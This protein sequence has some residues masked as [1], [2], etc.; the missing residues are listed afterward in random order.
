MASEPPAVVERR[1]L[2]FTLAIGGVAAVVVAFQFSQRAG[3]GVAVGTALAWLNGR[4]LQQ[5]L[6]TITTAS[7]AQAG[8]PKP[9]VPRSAYAKFLLRYALLAAVSYVMFKYFEVP[10]LSVLAGLCA[11][12]AAAMAE[13]IYEAVRKPN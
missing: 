1:I 4:W 13:F 9:R 11:L 6:D 2:L 5:G 12:G 7:R 8:A 3:I 10:V